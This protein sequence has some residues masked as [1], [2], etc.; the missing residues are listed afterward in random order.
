MAGLLNA[1]Q[2]GRRI[3]QPRL[4]HRFQQDRHGLARSRHRLTGSGE[5][6]EFRS[7][8]PD[9]LRACLHTVAELPD[10]IASPNPLEYFGFYGA[11][12]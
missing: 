1:L 10:L 5:A 3:P 6:L 11:D 12:R 9:A 2:A 4:H 8:L 7:P